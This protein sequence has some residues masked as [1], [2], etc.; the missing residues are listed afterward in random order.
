M[1]GWRVLGVVQ[2]PAAC[3]HG[4][5]YKQSMRPL[6]TLT[7][8]FGTRDSYVAQLKGELYAQGPSD[9]ELV[10]LTHEIAPQHVLEAA[11]FVRAAWPRFPSG[12]VHIVV[13]D[14][15]VG[16]ARRPLA[17]HA[18]LPQGAG[19]DQHWVGPDNG[20]MSLSFA[21]ALSAVELTP[22]LFARGPVSSTFHGRDVF[23]PAAARLAHGGNL[24]SL[25]RALSVAELA[26]LD[27]PAVE[28]TSEGVRG[29]VLHVDRFGN[30]ISNITRTELA[31]LAASASAPGAHADS[32]LA[33]LQALR[34][35]VGRVQC[36]F[37][38][39]YAEAPEATPVALVGS[40]DFVE[41]AVACGDAARTLRLGVGALLHVE[42]ARETAPHG[43]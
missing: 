19:G 5:R 1:S 9:L 2:R 6:I 28:R 21:A 20:V 17:L 8:D 3:V 24:A 25:G 41:I 30:L 38:R 40:S 12:T 11:L 26:R 16:S 7:T 34:I 42:I 39:T 29:R 35:R 22:T 23:A 27:F 13:V 31:A 37:I 33:H 36:P 4:Q 14:P 18:E 10:D 15:G 32:E 43:S